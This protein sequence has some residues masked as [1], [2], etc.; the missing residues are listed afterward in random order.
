MIGGD[1]PKNAGTEFGARLREVR[2]LD[3]NDLEAVERTNTRLLDVLDR[4]RELLGELIASVPSDVR[5]AN[6]CEHYD[7]LDKLV[8]H[9]DAA[10]FRVRLHVFQPG[11]FD[12][13]HNHRWTYTSRILRGS[14]R[15][16]LFGTD[17]DFQEGTDVREM[18]PILV[19]TEK[20]GNSYTLNHTVV[21][22]VTAEAHTVSLIV[23]GP[24]VKDR[25]LVADR[26]T[27][28]IWWQYGAAKESQAEAGKKRMSLTQIQ[29]STSL[30]ARLGV[31]PA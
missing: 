20:M 7:I 18:K 11:Y 22:S 31:V 16:A 14:Y 15:H 19:R 28:Q 4:D 3:W 13:P 26:V 17:S 9:D 25:F 5:L 23:R 24:A 10:G 8:I 30:L 1:S 27:N 12:R 29:E 2:E 21:H 6:L